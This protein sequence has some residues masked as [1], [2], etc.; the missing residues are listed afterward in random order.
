MAPNRLK[1]ARSV[2]WSRPSGFRPM[3]ISLGALGA[4][5]AALWGPCDP[6]RASVFCPFRPVCGFFT[7]RKTGSGPDL[8]PAGQPRHGVGGSKNDAKKC[9]FLFFVPFQ[10]NF[11]ESE[12]SLADFRSSNPNHP[13]L[14]RCPRLAFLPPSSPSLVYRGVCR[15]QVLVLGEEQKRRDGAQD[16]VRSGKNRPILLIFK[17]GES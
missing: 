15:P 4:R 6:P 10:L 13:R 2:H 3:A 17:R 5:S 9:V 12:A 7:R 11:V 14:V 8:G 16:I 1:W